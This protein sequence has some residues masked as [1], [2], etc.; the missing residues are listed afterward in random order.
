MRSVAPAAGLRGSKI[1]T[2]R[3]ASLA[4]LCAHLGVH[5]GA[6]RDAFAEIEALLSTVV[7]AHGTDHPELSAPQRALVGFRAELEPHLSAEEDELFPAAL[8]RERH[9]A[10]IE[11]RLLERHEREHAV[12]G[13]GSPRYASWEATTVAT[14]RSVTL[15]APS[16]M[17]SLPSSW[18]SN[19]TST[20]RTTFCCRECASWRP[21]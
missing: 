1:E 19:V 7:R 11:E 6:L 2:W 13:H 15:I 10:A 17:C 4:E 21:R 9:G 18:T 8:E 14:A 16:S 3:G 12:V 5:H 20:K